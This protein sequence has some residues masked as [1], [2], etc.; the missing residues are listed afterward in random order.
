MF[1]VVHVWLESVIKE[2][3]G[4]CS[5]VVATLD[6]PCVAVSP[7]GNYEEKALMLNRRLRLALLLYISN[8][9]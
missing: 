5:C 3:C 9:S 8:V 1:I 4:C 6:A 2:A 7:N